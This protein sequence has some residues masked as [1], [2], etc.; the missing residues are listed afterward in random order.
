MSLDD[1]QY[2]Y[3]VPLTALN[4]AVAA[5][6]LWVAT[7]TGSS[8]VLAEAIRSIADLSSQ[9]LTS[10]GLARTANRPAP[11]EIAFWTAAVGMLLYSFAAGIAILESVDRMTRPRPLAEPGL[12]YAVLL[13]GA[14]LQ[15]AQIALATSS[16]ATPRAPLANCERIRSGIGLLSAVA[17]LVGFLAADLGELLGADGYG[18]M[19]VGLCLALIAAMMAVEI[20]TALNSMA[21]PASQADPRTAHNAISTATAPQTLPAPVDSPNAERTPPPRKRRGK[22]R[23]R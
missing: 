9:A 15:V 10:V 4:G 5:A 23:R 8:V 14:V 18:T 16:P 20:R 21:T 2:P 17:A 19:A 12:G 13:V 3:L 6:K 22:R 11:G 7:L 1:I